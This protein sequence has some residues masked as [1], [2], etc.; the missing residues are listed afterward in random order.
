ML[1]ELLSIILV[2]AMGAGIAALGYQL[3]KAKKTIGQ[4]EASWRYARSCAQDTFRLL[5]EGQ[6]LLGRSVLLWRTP[7]ETLQEIFDSLTPQEQARIKTFS[8]EAAKIDAWDER[9]TRL[10][11]LYSQFIGQDGNTS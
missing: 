10:E 6:H 3:A 7:E 9:L 2:V 11:R 4:L 8:G 5:G 1:I